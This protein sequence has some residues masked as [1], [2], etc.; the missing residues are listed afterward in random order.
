MGYGRDATDVS[1]V[2]QFGALTLERLA[3]TVERAK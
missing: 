1:F 2:T 3:V